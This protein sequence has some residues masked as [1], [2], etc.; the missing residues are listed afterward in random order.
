MIVLVFIAAISQSVFLSAERWLGWRVLTKAANEL[1]RILK[2]T[3]TEMAPSRA[4]YL[5]KMPSRSF[6]F[7]NLL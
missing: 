3:I 2:L 6:T 5:L 1:S 4:F 7:K